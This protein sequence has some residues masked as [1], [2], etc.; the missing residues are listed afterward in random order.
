M[1]QADFDLCS[2]CYNEGLFGPDMVSA[3]FIKMDVTEASNANGGGWTD[4]ETLLLLEALELYGDNWNEIA[5]HVATKS[6]SQC[7]LHF[8]RLPVEDPFSD[9]ADN[10]AALT[11]S[12]APATTPISQT[13]STLEVEQEEKETAEKGPEDGTANVT[14]TDNAVKPRSGDLVIPPNLAAF[15]EA[16]NP[17]MAQVRCFLTI[18]SCSAHCAF[19]E[20]KLSQLLYRR[21]MVAIPR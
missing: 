21:D 7:I 17:V 4:Q 12:N 2:D 13:D 15:A 5:E 8:I 19:I 18:C 11:T 6:K 10:S 9:N 3:D 16:G 14:S 1:L 20:M